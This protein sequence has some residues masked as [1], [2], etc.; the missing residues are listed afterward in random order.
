[1]GG[2]LVYNTELTGGSTYYYQ[3]D[4]VAI[5]TIDPLPKNI[6]TPEEER[7][8]DFALKLREEFKTET[9]HACD[10]SSS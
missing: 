2:Y 5:G 9:E 10:S 4:G 6:L 7:V 1:V 8:R 3:K